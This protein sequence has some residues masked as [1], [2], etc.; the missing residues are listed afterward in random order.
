MI[1]MVGVLLRV[2]YLGELRG[3]PDLEHPPVDEGFSLYWATGLATGDWSLPP[4]AWGRDPGIRT[5]AYLRP[6]G[7]PFVLAGIFR[8]VGGNALGLRAVQMGLALAG[9]ILAWWVGRRLLGAGVGVAWAAFMV[10]G[11]PFLYFQG[12]LNGAWLLVL[13]LLVLTV[14]LLRLAQNPRWHWAAA[15]GGVL[16]LM[17]LV[18]PNALLFAPVLIAWGWWVVHRRSVSGRF[19]PMAFAAAMA[20]AIVLTPTILRNWRVEAAFVP[21]S[22]NGGLTL[23]HG[24]HD[25]AVGSM[26]NS[27][28]GLGMVSSPWM[29]PD[30]VARLELEMNRDLTFSEAS[31]IL[32]RR[33]VEWMVRHPGR[34][35]TL[36]GRRAA[37]FWGPDELAH[38]RV[39]GAD[40][41]VSPLLRRMPISF[42]TAVGGGLVGLAV[43]IVW[44]RREGSFNEGTKETLVALG[45]FV[46]TWFVSFMPF[47]ATSLY[48]MPVLP[49]L[50]LGSAVT[51]VEV[52]RGFRA[53]SKGAWGWLAVLAAAVV[54]TH[55]PIVP[56]DPGTARWHYDRGL[57]WMYEG[58]P[59]KAEACFRRALEENPGQRSAH[60]G[61]GKILL[62][63]GD[64]DRALF[65]FTTAADLKPEDSMAQGN[66]GLVLAQLGR[67]A[68]AEEAFSMALKSAPTNADSWS[69]AGICRERLGDRQ[70]A[71]TAYERTLAL[72]ET[73]LSAANNLAWL[74]ATV[75]ENRLRNGER[76]VTL[77]EKAVATS[78]SASTMDTLAAALAEVGR[79]DE[80]V[81][82]IDRA[83][84]L[85]PEGAPKA[86]GAKLKVRRD[87]YL[88][89]RPF[90]T[91]ATETPT[92]TEYQ[93]GKETGGEDAAHTR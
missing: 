79:F 34:E 87:L 36:I 56:A 78:P 81:V 57:A 64:I 65:H 63:R 51:V 21:V 66:R 88:D 16:G 4:E 80:A 84:A 47:F 90:R 53:G 72:D 13:L 42:P 28:T 68:E 73:H 58:Q 33:A 22:A 20:G 12:G 9:I 5:R 75:P 45:L 32:G 27:A 15:A 11:W 6:P 54:L 91:P 26:I 18:R 62:E 31:K 2:L 1:L 41:M 38:N 82:T 10:L 52:G 17:A 39:V 19:W 35:L 83:L 55:I 48:R 69:N 40:R 8:L 93:V 24:N 61:L 37:L 77:A 74:L 14:L 25:D 89:E 92:E 46:I 60:N 59:K 29:F 70:G 76:A 67:W 7:Y 23:Y 43:L 71:V 49:V 3:M 30:I 85:M 86:F 50:L 44:W